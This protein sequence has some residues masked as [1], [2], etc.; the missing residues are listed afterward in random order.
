MFRYDLYWH[1]MLFIS[2]YHWSTY[3]EAKCPNYICHHSYFEVIQSKNDKALQHIRLQL[4]GQN[5]FT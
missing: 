3:K 2:S 4:L 5:F 1:Q